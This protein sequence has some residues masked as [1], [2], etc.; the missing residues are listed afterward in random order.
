[1]PVRDGAGAAGFWIVLTDEGL[2]TS[3]KRPVGRF[4]I[5][6]VLFTSLAAMPGA[7]LAI[8]SLVT[9]SFVGLSTSLGVA[10]SLEGSFFASG[11]EIDDKGVEAADEGVNGVTGGAKLVSIE[12]SGADFP[13]TGADAETSLLFSLATTG[14]SFSRC[15]SIRELTAL[16]NSSKSISVICPLFFNLYVL[17]RLSP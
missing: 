15:L 5:T 10:S 8:E 13:S 7:L 14:A 11:R 4:A 1:M 2:T 17:L 12:F 3:M 9:F 6:D 16:S